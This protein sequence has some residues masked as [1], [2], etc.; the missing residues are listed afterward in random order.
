MIREIALV[1]A[2][3]MAGL[4]IGFV[5]GMRFMLWGDLKFWKL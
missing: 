1:L 2:G 3:L 4:V 5:T